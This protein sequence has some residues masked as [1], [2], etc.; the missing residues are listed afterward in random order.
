M[1]KG[2]EMPP[3]SIR[4]VEAYLEANH[5]N[6][7]SLLAAA[8]ITGDEDLYKEAVAKFPDDPRVA[9]DGWRR[10]KDKEERKKWLE[11]MKK[12]NPE[13]ALPNY[14][15]A[16]NFLKSGNTDSAIQEMEA[17]SGK[18]DYSYHSRESIQDA[19]EAYRAAGYSE[20]E[21]KLA[22]T[23]SL[24]LPHLAEMKGLAKALSDI[25]NGYKEAGDTASAEAVLRMGMQMGGR[26]APRESFLIEDLVG[27]AVQNLMLK[28][29]DPSAP[30]YVEGKTNGQL[31]DELTRRRASIK[32]LASE[33]EALFQNAT[34][35]DL[36]AFT[37]RAK[38]L[39]E[40]QAIQWLKDKYK[41]Q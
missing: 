12:A 2:E 15:S 27:I 25:S 5:R 14:L 39:G 8:R 6:A 28:G 22:A 30:S 37:D 40:L 18:T 26:V 11:V 20:T 13:N 29:A 1:L 3:I 16:A 21:A 19:E 23:W 24:L 41:P 38:V 17:A 10:T 7:A 31:M 34:E 32:E 4:E 9:F 36:A 35:Q 33:H